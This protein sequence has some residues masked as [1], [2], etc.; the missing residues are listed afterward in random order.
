MVEFDLPS[1]T[2]TCIIANVEAVAAE[3]RNVAARK[4]SVTLSSQV[5]LAPYQE[6]AN[7]LMAKVVVADT[8]LWRNFFSQVF[9]VIRQSI[10][11]RC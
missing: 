3:L 8:S 2:I 4:V 7:G 10:R 5:P 11:V 9:V 6:F 1:D